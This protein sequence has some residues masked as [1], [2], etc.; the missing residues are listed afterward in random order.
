MLKSSNFWVLK[1]EIMTCPI[2]PRREINLNGNKNLRGVTH[3]IVNNIAETIVKN[4]QFHFSV[5]VKQPSRYQ[6]NENCDELNESMAW[7]FFV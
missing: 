4:T 3:Y 2:V 7:F 1:E 6:L 5:S